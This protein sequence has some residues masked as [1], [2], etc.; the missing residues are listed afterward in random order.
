MQKGVGR[1][2]GD[3]LVLAREIE[4]DDL[5]SEPVGEPEPPVVLAG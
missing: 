4:C 2:G 5:V 3:H 1:E